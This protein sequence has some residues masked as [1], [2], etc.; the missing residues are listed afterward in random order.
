MGRGIEGFARGGGDPTHGAWRSSG[1]R[2]PIYLATRLALAEMLAKDERRLAV[3]DDV[4]N[5]TDT[6][7]LARIMA[8]LEEAARHLQELVL[9]CHPERYRGLD[10][11]NFIDLEA[12]LGNAAAS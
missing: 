7:R 2:V 6:S 9:T 5:A 10:A 4:L 12:V 3:L 8:I 1:E 11:A